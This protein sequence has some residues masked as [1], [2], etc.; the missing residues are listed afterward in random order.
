MA[1]VAV[2]T[3]AKEAGMSTHSGRTATTNKAACKRGAGAGASYSS[4]E[5]RTSWPNLEVADPSLSPALLAAT[6]AAAAGSDAVV[7]RVTGAM[8]GP[9]R[10]G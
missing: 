2:A 8:I 6:S 7:R 9:A 1:S 10:S 3:I 5:P 4:V